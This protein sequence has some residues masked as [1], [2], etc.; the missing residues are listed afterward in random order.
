MIDYRCNASYVKNLISA[1][2]G[3]LVL[4]NLAGYNQAASSD[5]GNRSMT[6]RPVT[7]EMVTF[8][9]RL[10]AF[11]F[12][13]SVLVAHGDSIVIHEAR[14]IAHVPSQT[15]NRLDT[16]FS[17]GSVTKQFTAGAIML[18]VQEGKLSVDDALPAFFENVPD[19][20]AAITVHHLLTHSAGLRDSYG[21][22]DIS[23]TEEELITQIFTQ[24]LLFKPGRGMSIPTA[25]IRC[26][27]LSFR[28]S[29]DWHM[30]ISCRMLCSNRPGWHR[31]D[32][33]IYPSNPKTRAVRI[34]KSWNLS[35]RLIALKTPGI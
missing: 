18:L 30:K 14:G 25:A 3:M 32:Y 2:A 16:R 15:P 9:D 27:R 31:Q 19:D 13:G 26:S 5:T 24:P 33:I 12:N 8:L 1:I 22:D 28:T 29:V 17:T 21:P 4:G 20:K 6:T 34:I 11:D 10:A 35:R 7:T 23:M